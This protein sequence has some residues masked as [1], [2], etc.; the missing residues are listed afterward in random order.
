MLCDGISVAL[1]DKGCKSF[2][3]NCKK[4]T[5][6]GTTPDYRY[7]LIKPEIFIEISSVNLS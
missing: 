2:T 1:L 3:R 5:H 4:T 6:R 7:A